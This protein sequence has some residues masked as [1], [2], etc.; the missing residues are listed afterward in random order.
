MKKIIELDPP[1]IDAND[2]KGKVSLFNKIYFT[3]TQAFKKA[4]SRNCYY[5]LGEKGSGKTALAYLLEITSQTVPKTDVKIQSRLF[6]IGETQYS[7][8]IT[9]KQKGKLEYS[10]YKTIWINILLYLVSDTI[11]EK[12]KSNNIFHKMLNKITGKFNHIKDAIEKYHSSHR[13]PELDC[14]I[15]IT[16]T[17]TSSGTAG[18]DIDIASSEINSE[19]VSERKV[20]Q[21]EIK[22]AL[23]DSE[24]AFREGISSLKLSSDIVICLDGLDMRPSSIDKT[25]YQSCINGLS[26]A[27]KELNQEFFS[28]IKDTKGKIRIVLLLRPDIFNTLPIQN[29]NCAVIDNAV[30]LK[31][32]TV[33]DP[34]RYKKGDLYRIVNHYFSSQ[35]DGNYNWENYFPSEEAFNFLLK[36]S[37]HRPR[38]FFFAIQRLIRLK[39]NNGTD[40]PFTLNDL[41][42]SEFKEDYSN[43]LLGETKNYANY[44]L[45]N[46]DFEIYISFFTYLNGSKYF[47]YA[48]FVK[49]FNQFRTDINKKREKLD[50]AEYLSNPAKFLQLLYDMNII[51]F[52]ERNDTFCHWSYRER[53][54]TMIMPK[55][56]C[57]TN[58]IYEVHYGL[59]LALNLGAV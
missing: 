30:F 27:A 53:R 50:N 23:L 54:E 4:L 10:D 38:D 40:V 11:I 46:G 52:R 22:R 29:S 36:R 7:N 51:G 26:E 44:Y 13:I 39:E 34:N 45:S 24:K 49:K 48:D 17:L 2:Y 5:F 3:E 8:F 19:R 9:M 1:S 25:E 18:L 14:I 59:V 6:S 56:T 43:Y 16:Q 41:D 15:E 28:K 33:S 55:I 31:W 57:N 21:P 35:N 20:A 37:F 58:Y 32:D 47:D 42:S 12:N